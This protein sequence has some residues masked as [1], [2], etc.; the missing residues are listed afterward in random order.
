M[1]P[2]SE[3]NFVVC[4]MATFAATVGYVCTKKIRGNPDTPLAG[5]SQASIE[6]S[7]PPALE[8][9]EKI[10]QSIAPMEPVQ[11][12]PSLTT[13]ER[14]R[15][16]KRKS[17]HDEDEY[18]NLGYPYNLGA[19]YPNKR[20]K[21]PPKED[22]AEATVEVS[23]PVLR[24][25]PPPE[26]LDIEPVTQHPANEAFVPK[27]ESSEVESFQGPSQTEETA[28]AVDEVAPKGEKIQD[29][30]PTKSSL[31]TPPTTPETTVFSAKVQ[32]KIDPHRFTSTSGGFASFASSPSAFKSFKA[33]TTTSRPAWSGLD[34]LSASNNDALNSSPPGLALTQTENKD[35]DQTPSN[36]S[37]VT[38]EEDE[39]IRSEV[40]GVKLFIKRGTK[41]FTDGMM[42]HIKLLS[43]RDRNSPRERLIFRREPLWQVMMNTRLFSAVRCTFEEEECILRVI[44][45]ESLVTSQKEKKEIVVYALKP[46][47]GCTK[48]DFI[49]FA[50]SVLASEGLITSGAKP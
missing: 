4:G 32:P 34:S 5:P 9:L 35:S 13:S 40:K 29:D 14:R 39:D 30:A 48:Q 7:V 16:L 49:G 31:P 42:G 36:Y 6:P 26:I 28:K 2:V 22:E 20:S 1:F 3:F 47:R 15:S 45:A 46:G 23:P 21:T 11:I 8:H 17:L 38:G 50:R 10:P 24:A 19:L 27:P 12:I 43:S 18:N 37:H 33:S 41:D 44:L 25:S